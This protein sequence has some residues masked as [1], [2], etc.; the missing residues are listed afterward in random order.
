MIG[1]IRAAAG[2]IIGRVAGGAIV[3]A[4]VNGYEYSQTGAGFGGSFSMGESLVSGAAAGAIVGGVVGALGAK[5]VAQAAG[6]R[7]AKAAAKKTAGATSKARVK[8]NS[9]AKR[10][11]SIINADRAAANDYRRS[12]NSKATSTM[13]HPVNAPIETA[14]APAASTASR[15]I[16]P[17]PFPPSNIQ[18]NIDASALHTAMKNG[19]AKFFGP[20]Q[21]AQIPGKFP[22]NRGVGIQKILDLQGGYGAAPSHNGIPMEQMSLFKPHIKAADLAMANRVKNQQQLTLGLHPTQ[23]E[24][25]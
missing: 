12:L 4:G 15:V 10:A 23:A 20:V 8:F 16:S 2:H 19:D 14:K 6:A 3:G 13:T 25:F 22:R 9:P 7:A 17:G 18:R 5:R 11:D 24:L 1:E 21:P